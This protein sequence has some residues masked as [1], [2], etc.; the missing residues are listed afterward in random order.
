MLISTNTRSRPVRLSSFSVSPLLLVVRCTDIADPDWSSF[1]EVSHRTKQV[2]VFTMRLSCVDALPTVSAKQIVSMRPKLQMG[3]VTAR[4]VIA[5]YV[6]DSGNAITP[7]ERYGFCGPC[8]GKA[9]TKDKSSPVPEVAV[10]TAHS[11][12][13][14]PTSCRF[15]DSDL[16]KEPRQLFYGKVF[17]D[18]VFLSGHAVHSASV[19]GFW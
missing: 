6:I 13:P 17:N 7:T 16:G 14:L 19:N 5:N 12:R 18:K 4:R 1:T 3:R 15:I 2:S 9:M 10:P 11:C 8:I